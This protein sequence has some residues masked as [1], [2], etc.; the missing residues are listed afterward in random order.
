MRHGTIFER[1][2]TA[3]T[4]WMKIIYLFDITQ[5]RIDAHELCERT[6]VG[7]TAASGILNKL[8]ENNK[9]RLGL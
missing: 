1:S 3:L 8:A 5:G 7:I 9:E 2:K 6:G 4:M